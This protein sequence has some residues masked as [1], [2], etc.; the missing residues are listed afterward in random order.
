[1]AVVAVRACGQAGFWGIS[2]SGFSVFTAVFEPEA[3]TV[4]LE[5][6]DM[7]SQPVEKRACEA[8]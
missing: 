1:M 6:M 8:L 2:G 3:F 5:N 7:M 4:H